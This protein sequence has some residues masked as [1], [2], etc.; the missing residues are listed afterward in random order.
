MIGVTSRGAFL[1]LESEWVIFLSTEDQHGPLTLNLRGGLELLND[2]P[3]GTTAYVLGGNISFPAAGVQ[4]HTSQAELWEPATRPAS[5]LLKAERLARL[6]AVMRLVL[7]RK[8]SGSACLAALIAEKSTASEVGNGFW[9]PHLHS[10]SKYL[11]DG[12]VAPILQALEPLLGYGNGLTPAGDDLVLGLL[13]A[14][15]RWG[16]V[17]YPGLDSAC[18]SQSIVSRAY[19]K[20]TTLAANLIECA[21]NGQADER[22]ILS[23][24]GLVCGAPET[25]ACAVMLAE[26]GHSSGLDALA[27]MALIVGNF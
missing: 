9:L 14:L 4:V 15:R 13:L 23:L 10:L 5:W 19:Q 21:A 8:P 16:D 22:L 12:Q 11:Q 7:A 18:L 25:A 1:H 6:K 27:G 2:L 3:N 26:L 17:I 20:T 24:D